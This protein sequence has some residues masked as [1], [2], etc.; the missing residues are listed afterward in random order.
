M[1]LRSV[2][3]T[4][5]S[6]QGLAFL[7]EG[8]PTTARSGKP[9]IVPRSHDLHERQHDGQLQ[10]WVKRDLVKDGVTLPVRIGL[11]Q[12]R[13]KEERAHKLL[14]DMCVTFLFFFLLFGEKADVK[15]E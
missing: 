15:T 1:L 11:K 2:L 10:G 3:L 6:V 12:G 13:E 8:G 5:A 9:L 14:M 7:V 4:V